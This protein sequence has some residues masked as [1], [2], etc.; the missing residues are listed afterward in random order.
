MRSHVRSSLL[1]L[2]AGLAAVAVAAPAAQASFGIEHVFA[3]NCKNTT[4]GEFGGP[5]VK[6]EELF[7]QAGGHPPAGITAF[8]VNTEGKFP[9]EAPSGVATGGVVTHVRT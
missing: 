1:I 2:A 5:P 4:C 9:N 6:N 8:K 3:A 7:T